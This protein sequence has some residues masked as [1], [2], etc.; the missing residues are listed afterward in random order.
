[1]LPLSGEHEKYGG[2]FLNSLE[3]SLFQRNNP[4]IELIIKDTKGDPKIA[5]KEFNNLLQED[6]SLLIGPLF[7]ECVKAIDILAM[8]RNIPILAFTNNIK[9]ARPGLWVLGINPGQQVK[10]LLDYSVAKGKKE[11]ALLL[12]NNQYGEIID[13]ELDIALKNNNLNLIRKV[14]FN[15]KN[16]NSKEPIRLITDGFI[17]LDIKEKENKPKVEQGQE[18]SKYEDFKLP[19]DSIFIAAS[20]QNLRIL[21]SQL[22]Y[23]NVDP[24]LVQFIGTSEWEAK[25]VISEPS[26]KGGIFAATTKSN[27]DFF[28]NKYKKYYNNQV[29]PIAMLGY[30]AIA[31]AEESVLNNKIDLNVLSKEEGFIGLRGLF[32]L[33]PDGIVERGLSIYKVEKNKLKIIDK[34][35]LLFE[36]F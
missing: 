9:L 32:R 18:D 13:T 16:I 35:S 28:I 21:S 29:P 6:I 33:R 14:Y 23:Y 7:S 8:D 36:N 15:P 11:F 34:A 31:L 17:D 25:N 26:L 30:D 19:Y 22:Q 1:M 12:P 2:A 5:K 20:G 27:S 24:K 10:R 4:S 3:L